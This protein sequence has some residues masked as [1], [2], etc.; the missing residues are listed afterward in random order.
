MWREGRRSPVPPSRAAVDLT[1]GAVILRTDVMRKQYFRVKETDR[2][3]E[4]AYRP[5]VTET[6][7]NMLALRASRILTQGHSVVVDAVF[8]SESERAV[9]AGLALAEN[10]RFSGLFLTADL[11]IRQQRIGR[12]D[13]DASD[14]TPEIAKL[15]EK[16]DLG[17]MDW[18]KVDAS[19]TSEQ[20]LHR[21]LAHLR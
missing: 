13:A 9:I 20:T 12:R 21:C 17:R 6:I 7:Y 5:E 4:S 2:L 8:A 1:P 14:A 16:Y 18:A 3:P 10:V 11:A 15:Q 19:G